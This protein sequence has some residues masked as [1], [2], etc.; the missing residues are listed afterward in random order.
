[1]AVTDRVLDEAQAEVR[2]RIVN[3]LS[4][5]SFAVLGIAEY[6]D[7]IAAVIAAEFP[8]AYWMPGRMIPPQTRYLCLRSEPEHSPE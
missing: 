5:R 3:A 8:V 7:H 2:R 1:V 4:H 6:A